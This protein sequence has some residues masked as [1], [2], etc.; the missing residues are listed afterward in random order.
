[1]RV[2]TINRQTSELATNE[3][4]IGAISIPTAILIS[5]DEE[6]RYTNSE[7]NV[8][9]VPSKVTF[10]ARDVFTD[11]GLRDYVISWDFNDDGVVDRE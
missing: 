4:S 9:R 1:M 2:T 11:L 7:V 8:G 5:S 3:F 6:V 10:D